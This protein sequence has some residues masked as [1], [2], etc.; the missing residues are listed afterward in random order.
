[1]TVSILYHQPGLGNIPRRTSPGN[2]ETW[3][4]GY[5]K[6]R[7][8]GSAAGRRMRSWGATM[9]KR[10]KKREEGEREGG[11][12]GGGGKGGREEE[13]EKGGWG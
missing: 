10:E 9:R 4:P 11:K 2:S 1:M 3:T 6:A 8:H 7:Q 12:K 5:D 13:G